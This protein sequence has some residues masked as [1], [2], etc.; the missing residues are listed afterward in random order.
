MMIEISEKEKTALSILLGLRQ[1]FALGRKN[2]ESYS[3]R[4][5]HTMFSEVIKKINR[6]ELR[7]LDTLQIVHHIPEKNPDPIWDEIDKHI[8]RSTIE[9]YNWKGVFGNSL[10]QEI[11][12]LKKGGLKV[13]DAFEKLSQ[14]VRV[15]DF[16]EEK[17]GKKR[18]ILEN[19]KISVHARYGENNTANKVM[20]DDNHD[21]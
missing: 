12:K 5:L 19:L 3:A 13:D 4:E 8:E 16:I 7:Y 15:R 2:N 17:K 20:G 18:K 11:L 14:D 21:N 1:K 6:N 9:R 10:T